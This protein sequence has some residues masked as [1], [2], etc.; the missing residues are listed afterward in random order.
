[1]VKSKAITA[2]EQR[3]WWV[4]ELLTHEDVYG[5]INQTSWNSAVVQQ[6]LHTFYQ[7]VFT[8]TMLKE[9]TLLTH[10]LE[11]R[12]SESKLV[13]NQKTKR[14]TFLIGVASFFT[15]ACLIVYIL[16]PYISINLS[17]E[18]SSILLHC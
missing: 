6:T 7:S 8:G 11:D 17:L 14:A 4:S 18:Y 12:L 16:S 10:L 2:E 3:V 9:S 5:K 13:L 15:L 1:M